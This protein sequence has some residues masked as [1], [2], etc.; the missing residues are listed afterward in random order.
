MDF[1]ASRS[2]FGRFLRFFSISGKGSFRDKLNRIVQG[3]DEDVK[4]VLVAF[5]DE[6]N[7]IG[8]K[9][10]W[11]LFRR[12]YR[13]VLFW[14][15][16]G[17]Y[18]SLPFQEMFTIPHGVLILSEPALIL[19]T[20]TSGSVLFDPVS[21][22]ITETVFS[23]QKGGI[24]GCYALAGF[25]ADIIYLCVE[26]LEGEKTEKKPTQ[27]VPVFKEKASQPPYSGYGVL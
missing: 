17:V 15:L 27:P 23:P 3:E 18:N 4:T 6:N 19:L 24:L 16:N 12:K 1:S 22:R 20:Q 2:F 8:Y 13:T 5:H 26:L 10:Y 21:A 11:R 25:S 14:K 9:I 7:Y